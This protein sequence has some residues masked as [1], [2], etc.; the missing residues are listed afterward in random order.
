MNET[1]T[2]SILGDALKWSFRLLFGLVGL[3]AMAW[4]VTGISRVAPDSQAVVARFGRVIGESGP[5]LL[6]SWP[7]PIEHITVLPSPGRQVQ[8]SPESLEVGG[9][10]PPPGDELSTGYIVNDEAREN[11][12]FFLTGDGGIV[13][14][15][16]TVFYQIKSATAYVT[17][18][19]HVEPALR[20]AVVAS[21]VRVC[22][23]RDTDSILV[24]RPERANDPSYAAR[25]ERFRTDLVALIN[26]R[27]DAM[28][29]ARDGL[30]IHVARTDVVASIPAGAKASF[31][32][33]LQVSQ[34]V[35]R[36]LAQARTT[37]EI[38]RQTAEQTRAQTL[39]E[40]RAKAKETVSAAESDSALVLAL[41]KDTTMSHSTV[42][43]Q[44]YRERIKSLFDVAERVDT[45]PA[46][47]AG[48][49]I[50]PGVG[51]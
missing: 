33:V 39:D 43:E 14:L 51:Q 48:R 26:Q 24:A 27:L 20:R 34:Q 42:L 4:A 19:D 37:A 31:D 47:G 28:A 1:P 10:L 16:V 2:T 17:S 8:F 11:T 13:H 41:G 6:V 3:L 9:S 35:E 38:R 32:N 23:S 7:A 46:G 29:D 21:A 12:W 40:A 36:T 30:G 45:V 25:R 22:A 44:L 18:A 5:G 50:V 49:V 15:R